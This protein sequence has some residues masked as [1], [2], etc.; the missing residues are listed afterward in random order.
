MSTKN[1]KQSDGWK[2][3]FLN[4][5]KQEPHYDDSHGLL[6]CGDCFEIM[7]QMPKECVDLTI[8][9]PPY[10]LGNDHHTGSKRHEVYFDLRPEKD[11]Q[12]WQKGFL[13]CK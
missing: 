13:V 10:N 11:Y 6:Y 2:A 3:K 12:F 4:S 9:S 7:S 8:T 1:L 5:I